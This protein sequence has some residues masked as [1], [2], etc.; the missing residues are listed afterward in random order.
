MSSVQSCCFSSRVS[1]TRCLGVPSRRRAQAHAAEHEAPFTRR[2][3]VATTT[4]IALATLL[5][6]PASAAGDAA[7]SGARLGIDEVL[8]RLQVCFQVRSGMTCSN[9]RSLNTVLL[10]LSKRAVQATCFALQ[11]GQYYVSGRL[12]RGIF[13]PDCVFIDPTVRVQGKSGPV[14]PEATAP[15]APSKHK[16]MRY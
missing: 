6:E 7:P 2:S 5:R 4:S 14:P 12:D 16:P 3:L 15:I 1:S 10:P 9:Q 8:Q 11:E 13:E